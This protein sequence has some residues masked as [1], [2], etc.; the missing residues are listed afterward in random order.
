M[1]PITYYSRDDME[2]GVLALTQEEL[3]VLNAALDFVLNGTKLVDDIVYDLHDE[4]REGIH[5]LTWRE[6]DPDGL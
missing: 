4:V 6:G 5:H 2:F 1:E 3:H